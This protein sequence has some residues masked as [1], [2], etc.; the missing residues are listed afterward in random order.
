MID[1]APYTQKLE[2]LKEWIADRVD[3]NISPPIWVNMEAINFKYSVEDILRI[4]EQTGFIA[5]REEA[6]I[7]NPA[8]PFSFEEYCKYKQQK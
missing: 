6:V 1:I 2:L 7:K 3:G 8:L 5:Y 4:Y